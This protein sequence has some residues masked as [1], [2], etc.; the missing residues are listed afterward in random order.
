MFECYRSHRQA[1]ARCLPE[2]SGYRRAPA[3]PDGST[4]G[5]RRLKPDSERLLGEVIDVWPR[6]PSDYP[7]P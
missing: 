5:N 7:S 3:S 1:L 6:G 2:K 4:L